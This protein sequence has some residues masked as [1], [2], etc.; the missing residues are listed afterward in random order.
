[1]AL[2]GLGLVHA[3]SGSDGSVPPGSGSDAGASA[4]ATMSDASASFPEDGAPPDTA[5][6]DTGSAGDANFGDAAAPD[7][8]PPNTVVS[9]AL[10]DDHSCALLANGE[11]WCWGF[12]ADGEQGSGST[13]ALVH[14]PTKVANLPAAVAIGARRGRS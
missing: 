11:V 9:L 3:C 10:G 2:H 6:S 1:M 13:D 4:D 8:T 7:A 5:Q 12:N 14:A